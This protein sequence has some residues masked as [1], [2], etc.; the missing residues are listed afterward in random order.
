MPELPEV[1]RTAMSLNQRLQ[2]ST[3]NEINILSGR[4]IR[5]GNPKGYDEFIT[6]LPAKVE[7][8]DFRGKLILFHLIDR[9]GMKWW[10]WN[11]LGMSGGWKSEH[12]KHGHVEIVSTNGKYYFTD[13]RNFGTMKFVNSEVETKR[14]VESMGPNHLNDAID[15]ATF[16]HRLMLKSDQTLAEVLMNQGLIGGIGNY[17]KAEVLYR[18]RLS[19]H[20]KV[21]TLSDVDFSNLNAATEEVVKGSFANGGA[22]IRTYS[23]MEN[24]KGDFP[25]FFQVYGRKTCEN[26]FEV[27]REQTLDGR[28]TWWCPD[29]QI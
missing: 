1:S 4:Y 14:K 5:H 3:I 12:T 11:T 20:R 2:N 18:A 13:A 16:K 24:E 15:D 7:K 21:E 25:F 17:I 8:V 26:G 29:I 23:G 27:V 10:I 28:T 19:P 22:S 6:K 9:D